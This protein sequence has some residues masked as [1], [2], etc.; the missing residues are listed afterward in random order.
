MC[1]KSKS[2]CDNLRCGMNINASEARRPIAEYYC[3]NGQPH[4]PFYD[5]HGAGAELA[6]VFRSVIISLNMKCKDK[7]QIGNAM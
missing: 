7:F 3:N 1:I 5:F 4:L 6:S 2:K